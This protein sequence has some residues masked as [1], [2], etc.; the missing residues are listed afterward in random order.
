MGNPRR[1]LNTPRYDPSHCDRFQEGKGN[2]KS[3]P[4][5]APLP[6]IAFE[7]DEPRRGSQMTKC[8][9]DDRRTDGVNVLARGGE[10][11]EVAGK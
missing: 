8:K 1:Y 9:F 5:D 11:N 3:R 4:G 10:G 6:D 2:V 7:E